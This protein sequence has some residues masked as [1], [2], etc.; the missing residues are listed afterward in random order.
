MSV[1]RNPSA[2]VRLREEL[3]RTRIAGKPEVVK[4]IHELNLFR[5]VCFCRLRRSRVAAA[6]GRPVVVFGEEAKSSFGVL[7]LE[8]DADLILRLAV[9]LVLQNAFQD[10]AVLWQGSLGLI[11]FPG[12]ATGD[13]DQFPLLAGLRRSCQ[14]NRAEEK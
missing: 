2:A 13:R 8:Y 5:T 12:G 4:R 10:F 1:Y 14:E 3:G 9:S 7:A 6:Q 11:D